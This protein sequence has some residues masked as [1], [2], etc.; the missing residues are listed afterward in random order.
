MTTPSR[1]HVICIIGT[2][3]EVIKMAP[4]IRAL[5]DDG[6]F[7]LTVLCSGQHRDLLAPLLKWFDITVDDDLAVMTED[8]SLAMLSSRLM[9]SFERH[10]SAARPDLVMAQGD[11]T[12]V[13]CAALTSFY[14]RI[15]FA[16]VE[17][18]LRSF[19]L[20]NPFPEELN[21]VVAGRLARFHFCPTQGAAQH[22]LAEGAPPASVHVTGNTVIDA[23]HFTTAALERDPPSG[24]AHEILLTA[25]RRENF[26]APLENVFRA[27]RQL[28]DEFPELS[29]L[30][31]VH[32]NPN[33][34]KPAHA[35]LGNHPQITL[36]EPLSYP[37]LVRAMQD[38]RFILTDSGGIQEE[39]P[40]LGKPVLV[41]RS[42]T[43]R[44]EAVD[45]G[46]AK[47]IGSDLDAIVTESRR[48]LTD[49]DHY[50]TMAQGGSPYGDGHAAAR[51]VRILKDQL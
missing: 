10:F 31:P 41:L 27:V 39:A 33:V 44:P 30:Y 4:V 20:D 34:H 32:P 38:A 24:R 23:L 5:R 8:Q 16:H 22:V 2:R 14:Q 21:R 28:C 37:E 1:K 17:A 11:T 47:L 46:V 25:H 9:V 49:G 12:T 48:L 40:A 3:P 15:P 35:L 6:R 26:G 50:K 36:T 45:M 42:V 43:E 19:D 51:I 18:G 13:M 29:V 7:R